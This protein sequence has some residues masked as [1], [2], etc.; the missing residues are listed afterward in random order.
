MNQQA[1]STV[2][3]FWTSELPRLLVLLVGVVVVAAEK[4]CQDSCSKTFLSPKLGFCTMDLRNE[5]LDWT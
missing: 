1:C 5:I 2:G 4:V 3:T